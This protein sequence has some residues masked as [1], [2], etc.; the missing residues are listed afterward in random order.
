[1]GTTNALVAYPCATAPP[2]TP[3]NLPLHLFARGLFMKYKASYRWQ[4]PLL[5]G[6]QATL[7][8][9]TNLSDW[10]SCAVVTNQGMAVEWGHWG[11]ADPKRF[12]RIVPQ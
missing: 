1:D 6:G 12:F 9:S 3:M 5:L 4:L 2:E 11:S 7:Q 10:V 8:F